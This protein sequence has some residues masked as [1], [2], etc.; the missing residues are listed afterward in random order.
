MLCPLA[1][2]VGRELGYLIRLKRRKMMGIECYFIPSFLALVQLFL[3]G[4]VYKNESPKTLYQWKRG[5]DCKREMEKIYP[6]VDRMMDEMNTLRHI[7]DQVRFQPRYPVDRV[8][9]QNVL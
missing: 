9:A 7:D 2:V 8:R 1:I 6:H 3:L 4:F 5:E